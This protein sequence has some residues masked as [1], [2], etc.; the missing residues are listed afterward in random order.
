MTASSALDLIRSTPCPATSSKNTKKASVKSK[1]K[2]QPNKD[3]KKAGVFA[4][5]AKLLRRAGDTAATLK[6]FEVAVAD[7][8]TCVTA[9]EAI[10]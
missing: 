8:G 7:A 6:K 2:E 5:R 3:K 9:H 1:I 4:E 10:G